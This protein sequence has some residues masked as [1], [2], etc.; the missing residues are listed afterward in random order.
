MNA[1]RV[2]TSCQV[3][4][5]YQSEFFDLCY[6]V[7]VILVLI[8]VVEVIITSNPCDVS[9]ISFAGNCQSVGRRTSCNSTEYGRIAA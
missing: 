4:F 1:V 7:V 8:L 9:H 6:R 3:F 5:K 2:L